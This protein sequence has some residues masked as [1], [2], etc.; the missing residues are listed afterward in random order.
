MLKKLTLFV[1][2]LILCLSTQ[3]QIEKN[4]EIQEFNNLAYLPAGK[5][6][7]DSLQRLNL[8]MPKGI[9][10]PPLL[11]WIGGGAWSFVNR[12]MEMDLARKIAERGIAVA[13]VGHRLSSAVWSNPE[14]NEGVQHPAHTYDVVQA[15]EWLS[16]NAD[17]YGF[18]R[19]KLFI[20]GFSSGAYVATILLLDPQ[21]LEST[22]LKKEQFLG[23]IPVSGA[24]DIQH[25][26]DFIKASEQSHLADQHVRA[27]FGPTDDHLKKASATEFLDKLEWPM[28]LF[29]D[30]GIYTYTK[31]FEEKLHA[32]TEYSDYEA[33]YV[34]H[35]GHGPLWRNLSFEANSPYRKQIVDFILKRS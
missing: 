1:L 17:A 22:K 26:H 5:M 15:C 16:E 31:V 8:V 30:G 12:H 29:A 32:D 18:D 20:G 24:F 9:E 23:L 11:V 4:F 35:L 19:N 6:E 28:L 7:V 2:A 21:F 14:Q 33:V 27:V 13:S 3:A 25:Y 34:Y 10:N